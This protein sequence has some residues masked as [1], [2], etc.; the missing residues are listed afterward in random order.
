MTEWKLATT[1]INTSTKVRALYCLMVFAK[2]TWHNAYNSD[3][4]SLK[5]KYY[6]STQN[7]FYIRNIPVNH[8]IITNI[9]IIYLVQHII[10]VYIVK[11]W[12][13]DFWNRNLLNYFARMVF[14]NNRFS[15]VLHRSIF[16]QLIY[17]SKY[18]TLREDF[19]LSPK[20]FTWKH[21]VFIFIIPSIKWYE[22]ITRQNW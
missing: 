2:I 11:L 12:N 13:L 14:R 3:F 8:K 5:L 18:A 7:S 4:T 16:V 20:T 19:T 15:F 21:L 1:S 10:L 9:F 22:D 17:S 6:R